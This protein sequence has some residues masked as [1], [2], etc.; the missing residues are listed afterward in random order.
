MV[1]LFRDGTSDRLLEKVRALREKTTIYPQDDR[2]FHAFC[3]TPFD[4]VKVVIVGQDPYHG[5]GQAHGLAFSVP[6][7][8]TAPP[9]L[10]N[11][12]REVAGDTG[13]KPGTQTTDLSGW[14]DQG[15]LLMNTLLTVEEGKPMS[16][17]NL[18]WEALTSQAIIEL[19][20]QRKHLVFMLWGSKAQ[21]L[22]P[23]I[24]TTK[25]LILTA[26]H[27]SP[28]SAFRGF[29][30]CRHFSQTNAWLESRDLSPV[31]W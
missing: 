13:K 17:R 19:S 27:P 25:H 1:P 15:V 29:F 4:E 24:D 31:R 16:H 21:A 9:S 28:L 20:S 3:R 7:G 14:A 11:I 6:E 18:G 12:L 8:V 26:A 5:K 22:S 10:R 30:G 2:V 23:L